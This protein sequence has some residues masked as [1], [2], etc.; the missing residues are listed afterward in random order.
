M[1]WDLTVIYASFEDPAFKADFESLTPRMN[2]LR[3]TLASDRQE[4]ALLETAVDQIS[5]LMN[6][7]TKL[8]SFTQLTLATDAT[9]AAAGSALDKLMEKSVDL[10]RCQSA[11]MRRL[12]AV[13][14]LDALI[15]ASPK[16]TA[17]GFAL[18]SGKA[19]AAHTMDEALEPWL[20]RMSLSGGEAFS[21]LRDKLDA[22][23]L[24][25][26]RGEAIPLSAA[27]AKAY[28]PDPDVRREAYQAELKSYDKMA[29]PMS[30][31]LDSIK[32]EADVLKEARHFD[33]ILN[34]TLFESNMDRETLD[35]MLTAIREYL[36]DFRRYFRCKAK[37]LG[38][39]DG[40]PF[41]D[42]F[43]PVGG[44]ARTYTVE[45]ARQILIDAF[46]PFN[47]E[48][49]GFIANAFDNA[50]IDM[51]P[52][53]GKGGGAFCEGIHCLGISRILTNFAG[54][55]SDISTLAHEL[56]HAWHNHCMKELPVLMTDYPMPLAETASIFN[57]TVLIHEALK[58]APDDMAFALIEGEL[59]E[60]A[61]VIVDIYSRYLFET[62]VIETRKDHTLSVD[63]LKDAM[64]RAQDTAYGN[65]LAKDLRHPYMWAC[66][67]H[68]YF[69]GAHFYNF[70]YAFGLLFGKGVFS[71]YQAK[72]SA[73]VPEYNR[74][75]A[76]CG[77]D[78]VKNV[79]ASAGI[80]VHS[81]DFWRSSLAVVR[82]T[83]NQFEDL[84]N[85]R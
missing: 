75:L 62:E 25:D 79:A 20:L 21:Q 66:K 74:L 48:M 44:S 33:T 2:T 82:E 41:Y 31:C 35:A 19:H 37:L 85:K 84:C 16:L 52:R 17:N 24:V 83:I 11:L 58:T 54:S 23:H 47:P 42:L 59:M 56:G 64:L 55:Y 81:V 70:P 78:T 53:K 12:G 29:L 7:F 34:M 57:E 43:A 26:F 5:D 46:T 61:Q 38:H 67:T 49:A 77:S 13:Q 27:R 32:A 73:F 15:T 3:E 8:Y 4:L 80:N 69:T 6:A 68:Y 40:L 18:R 65:G 10:S 76:S 51:F 39:A 45:E 72:G 1:Q 60:A 50:W 63:E 28:D 22:T 30:Y 14:D 71:L 36:P 9:H